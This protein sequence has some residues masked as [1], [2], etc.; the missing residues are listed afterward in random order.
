MSFFLG[1]AARRAAPPFGI[2]MLGRNEFALRN[3]PPPPAAPNL[4]RT[5]GAAQKGRWV[6]FLLTVPMLKISIL[7]VLSKK[8]GHP[9]GCPSFLGFGRQRAAFNDR[10]RGGAPAP[11]PVCPPAADHSLDGY[12]GA[13]A[14]P[15]IPAGGLTPGR[16]QRARW[17]RQRRGGIGAGSPGAAGNR[18][19][20]CESHLKS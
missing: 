17:L 6:V 15:H 18:A 14:R 3:S 20:N 5:R 11:A 2:S 9:Q 8:E 12:K 4:R 16:C 13:G 7:T 19:E 10:G 1:S